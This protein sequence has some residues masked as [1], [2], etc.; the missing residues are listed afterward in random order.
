VSE[1]N[2]YAS[3]FDHTAEPEEPPRGTVLAYQ[4]VG[5][6]G[7]LLD[8]LSFRAGDGKWYT[9][10]KM[11]LQGVT[12]RDLLGALRTAAV[13]PIRYATG[14]AEL[15]S[16]GTVLGRREVDGPHPVDDP[17]VTLTRAIPGY[18]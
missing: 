2:E 18:R 15:V 12:W 1:N 13:G 16:V 17:S 7:L 9:T 14:W 8:Y 10:G 3:P 11:S 4:R 6:N 5:R